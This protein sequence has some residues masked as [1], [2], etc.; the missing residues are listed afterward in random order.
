MK[1]NNVFQVGI[2]GGIGSGKSTVCKAFHV[3][4]IRIYDADTSAKWLMEHDNELVEKIKEAFGKEAYA[5]DGQLDRLHM[6]TAAFANQKQTDILNNLVHPQVGRHYAAW[7][8]EHHSAPYLVKEAAL[9]FE[10]NSHL[11]LHCI[12][13]VSAP[14]PIRIARIQQ[15]DTN[16]ALE[17][18]Q[19]ILIRQWSDEQRE[20]LADF[21]ILNS[22]EIPLL[23]QILNLHAQFSDSALQA[24]Y[25]V[26][27]PA[28]H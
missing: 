21:C 14:E 12:V 9:M 2:T 28:T 16:R 17:Q 7:V 11:A 8:N 18:I 22:G 20:D 13:A 24:H 4:G 10:S 26:Q 6:R 23:Q 15:R 19:A 3:L 25:G 27:K 5:K 1:N